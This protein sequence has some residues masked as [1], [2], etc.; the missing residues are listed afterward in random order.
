VP[1]QHTNAACSDVSI[2]S[3][4]RSSKSID[5]IVVKSRKTD[6]PVR[7]LEQTFA[8]LRSYRIKLNPEKC[9]FGIPKGKLLSFIVSEQ[10]IKANP[11]KIVAIWNLG[12]ITNLKGSQK[13]MGCLASLSRFILRL[14]EQGMPL[15][16][17]LKKSDQFRWTDETQEAFD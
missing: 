11:K 1:G 12:S 15:Y 16:K 9:V 8:R 6:H 10:G 14:R 7:N 4:E 5:D 13:P 17:L 3:S 2:T